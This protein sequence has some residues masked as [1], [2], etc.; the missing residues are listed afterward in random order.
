[1]CTAS[2]LM[3]VSVPEE[4]AQIINGVSSED[5]DQA[6]L[7]HTNND[8][9]YSV[10]TNEAYQD[11]DNHKDQSFSLYQ[12][13]T[14][15]SSSKNQVDDKDR[16]DQDNSV[17][18]DSGILGNLMEAKNKVGDG[19]LIESIDTIRAAIDSEGMEMIKTGINIVLETVLHGI[20][21]G[22][23]PSVDRVRRD[24]EGDKRSYL[25]T[26]VSLVGAM[27]GRLRCSH[28]IACRLGKWFQGRLPSAQLVVMMIESF[29]PDAFLEWFGVVKISVID[30][31]DN[32]D[33]NY[34]CSLQ[35]MIEN[36]DE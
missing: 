6:T 31:S 3:T 4:T 23:F 36:D 20:L 12:M 7:E 21:Q 33:A 2:R 5:T 14:F 34:E 10:Q 26:F 30:R 29:V 22:F 8:H 24:A 13:F 32:C 35:E 16:L 25:D 27:M 18:L 19:I 17:N 11:N 9:A 28:F 1:V 15:K